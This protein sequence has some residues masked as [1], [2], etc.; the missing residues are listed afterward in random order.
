MKK[1]LFVCI[2]NSCRSQMA[3]GFARKFG[4][5]VLETYS[6]GSKPSKKV[7]SD[8]IKVMKESGIDISSYKPKGFKDL[9]ITTFDYVITLGCGD[10]CPFIPAKKHIDWHIDNPK[11]KDIEYF[12]ETRDFID[13]KVKWLIQEIKLKSGG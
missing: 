13:D 4:K 8:A 5:D 6:A 9:P 2:E 7:N 3:E 11:G 10:I 12:R 1:V